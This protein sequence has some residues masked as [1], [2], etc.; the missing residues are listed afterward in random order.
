MNKAKPAGL[1][2]VATCEW[3]WR[4]SAS[5]TWTQFNEEHKLAREVEECRASVGERWVTLW[6]PKGAVIRLG[7]SRD[8]RDAFAQTYRH[9]YGR[10]SENLIE[11]KLRPAEVAA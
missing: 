6:L 2:A 11:I 3:F 5:H 9:R 8:G 4:A 7:R 10:D 1:A